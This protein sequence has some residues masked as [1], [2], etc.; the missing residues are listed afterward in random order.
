M[1]MLTATLQEGIKTS[2]IPAAEEEG[3]KHRG[4]VVIVEV[5]RGSTVDGF[6][7]GAS[8]QMEIAVEM[9]RLQPNNLFLLVFL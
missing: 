9:C 2:R 1:D 5:T 3:Q 7:A 6:E 4:E 8:L